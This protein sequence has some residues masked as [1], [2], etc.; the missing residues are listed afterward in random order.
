MKKKNL[1]KCGVLA[2]G[3]TLCGAGAISTVNTSVS[4]R[5][6]AEETETTPVV[7]ETTTNEEENW[8]DKIIQFKDTILVPLLSGVSIT[9]ILSVV[10][11]IILNTIR[12]K[13]L[14]KKCIES[15]AKLA[16]ATAIL[17][18]ITKIYNDIADD[19]KINEETRTII[20]TQ[21]TDLIEK[22]N[23]NNEKVAKI[24]KIE[25]ILKLLVQLEIKLAK[26]SS[27]VVASGAIKDVNEI[28]KLIKEF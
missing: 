26:A 9:S 16:E 23:A 18:T 22:I 3:L 28:T 8:K 20:E 12:G 14:D 6:V 27:D 15:E 24:E 2:F 21:M 4:A 19:K 25:P 17:S 10:I 5:A 11:T 7:E 1:I 13:K